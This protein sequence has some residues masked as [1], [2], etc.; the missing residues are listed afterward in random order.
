MMQK[1]GYKKSE[2]GRTTIWK[3]FWQKGVG[4]GVE[5]SCVVEYQKLVGLNNDFVI[6]SI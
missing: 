6:F 3:R 5:R 4:V 2:E 1:E